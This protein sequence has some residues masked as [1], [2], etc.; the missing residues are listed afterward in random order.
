MSNS[1][2]FV[3]E[4]IL[5]FGKLE[6]LIDDLISIETWKEKVYP[7]LVDSFAG[8]NTMRVYFILYH[9]A[10]VVNLLEI[11]IYHRHICEACGERMIELVDFCARKLSR[12]NGGYD[13]RV[14]EPIQNIIGEDGSGAKEFAESLANRDPKE[15]LAQYLTEIEYRV[16]ISACAISRLICE[17]ADALPL[18]VV[19]RITDTHDFLGS[20]I[21]FL[22]PFH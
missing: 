8:R 6:M 11:L 10:T 5:T 13:F 12:L 21:H 2:E 16:C 22:L 9:E 18:S 3:L 4:A 17:H 1:D 7:I 20:S 19:S 15:E 14:H